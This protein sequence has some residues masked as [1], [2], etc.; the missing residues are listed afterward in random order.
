MNH[1]SIEYLSLDRID[2]ERQVRENANDD[3]LAYLAASLTK[4]Q[5]QPVRVRPRSS[6]YLV[7]AGHRRVRAARLAGLPT[8]AA[9]VDRRDLTTADV[10]IQQL[11][12]NLARKAL[13]P[14]ET[15][16]GIQRILAE[17]GASLTDVAGML[18]LSVATVSRLMALL[19]LPPEIQHKVESGAIPASTAYEI[20]KV[21]DVAKQH[22]LSQLAAK[23]ELK[24]DKVKSAASKKPK[25]ASPEQKQPTF[26]MKVP[27]GDEGAFSLSGPI[28]PLKRFIS[29]LDELLA[30]ARDAERQG[31]ELPQFVNQLKSKGPAKA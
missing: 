26:R 20:A 16:L 27:A 2:E 6:R 19:S 25:T 5:L 10:L 7:I 13:K 1:E 3:G 24:R 15:A 31:I 29:C 8:I 18:D 12:A 9:I 17:T 22:E 21:S 11:A 28:V 4:G 14:V 23:G 30:W